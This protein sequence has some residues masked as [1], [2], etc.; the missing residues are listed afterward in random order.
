MFPL[1]DMK[2][3]EQYWLHDLPSKFD[4]NRYQNFF[5]VVLDK[6]ILLKTTL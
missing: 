6:H 1:S 5:I 2:I 3:F 4:S